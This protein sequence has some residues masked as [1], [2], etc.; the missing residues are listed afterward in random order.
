[1][2]NM[3]ET[4]SQGKTGMDLHWNETEPNLKTLYIL[5]RFYQLK[6]V[7]AQSLVKLL[8]SFAR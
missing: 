5:Y 2:A 1:M 7:D 8:L 6:D 3:S 4:K